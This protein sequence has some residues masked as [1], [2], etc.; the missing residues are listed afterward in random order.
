MSADGSASAVAP[1]AEPAP[2]VD[3]TRAVVATVFRDYLPG[4]GALGVVAYGV[5]RLGYMFFYARLRTTPEEV[6][7]T[8]AR[9]LA[10]SLVG[11]VEL[12][13]LM[14]MMLGIVVTLGWAA[15]T[16]WTR[17]RRSTPTGTA[18]GGRGALAATARTAAL[19]CVGGAAAA[20]LVSLPV[21]AWWQGGLA[22][23]GQTVRNVYFIGIPYLP[24]LAVQAVPADVVWTD[25][26]AEPGFPLAQRPC[27]MYLGGSDGTAV[28]YDV[29][30]RE[31]IRVP[32]SDIVVSLR[33][34]YF[35]P[36]E[37]Q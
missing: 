37:C 32:L 18:P 28:F 29:Q 26:S 33:Y 27:L 9:I 1:A 34:T 35:V 17:W 13:L 2:E 16:L 12:I 19:R 15:R 22:Q 20:V 21:L 14:A 36:P 10:E 7:Y 8:Y 30:S 11:A 4:L 3:R 23:G 31:S 5:L 24:V 6:G 25:G